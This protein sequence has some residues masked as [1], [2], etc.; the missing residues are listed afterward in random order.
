MGK[1]LHADI[2]EQVLGA[3]FAVHS[4]LGPGFLE[5]IYEEALCH[6]LQLRG[7]GYERQVTVPITY[8]GAKVG[9][10]VLDLIVN[11]KVVIELKAITEV[12]DIH[13]AIVLSYLAASKLSVA[14]LINF[15]QQSLTSKR[16]VR[17]VRSGPF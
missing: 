9:I 15:G 2:T 10:H 16:V 11:G 5:S 7:M 8:K 14:I 6:E 4:T 13:R 1:L 17:E 12:A 3:A